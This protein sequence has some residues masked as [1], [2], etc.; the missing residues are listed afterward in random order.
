MRR[1][2]AQHARGRLQESC[3]SVSAAL[4][5]VCMHMHGVFSVR[6]LLALLVMGLGQ[7]GTGN[8]ACEMASFHGFTDVK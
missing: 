5:Q 3:R 2:H 4:L 6:G 8:D 7:F 1:M